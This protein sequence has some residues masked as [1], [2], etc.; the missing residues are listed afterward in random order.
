M[1]L[2]KYGLGADRKISLIRTWV[3]AFT[4]EFLLLTA[5]SIFCIKYYVISLKITEVMQNKEDK[6]IAIK[7]YSVITAQIIFIIL[8]L[9]WFPSYN[10]DDKTLHALYSFIDGLPSYFIVLI[11]VLAFLNLRNS[12]GINYSLSKYQILL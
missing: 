9:S 12:G 3:C 2:Y 1:L 4:W 7:V 5:H 10:T 6:Y 8:A 11:L